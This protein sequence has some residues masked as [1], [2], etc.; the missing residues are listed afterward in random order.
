MSDNLVLSILNDGE[1]V[2]SHGVASL[3]PRRKLAG[4]AQPSSP[5]ATNVLPSLALVSTVQISVLDPSPSSAPSLLHPSEDD[6]GRRK[7]ELS[8]EWGTELARLNQPKTAHSPRLK[9]QETFGGGK[10]AVV[11]PSEKGIEAGRDRH[12]SKIQR[13][14]GDVQIFNSKDASSYDLLS[15]VGIHD[16]NELNLDND[17]DPL[18]SSSSY[19]LEEGM[20]IAEGIFGFDAP[21]DAAHSPPIYYDSLDILPTFSPNVLGGSNL[22]HYMNKGRALPSGDSWTPGSLSPPLTSPSLTFTPSEYVPSTSPSPYPPYRTLG[23]TL[24]PHQVWEQGNHAFL[25]MRSPSLPGALENKDLLLGEGTVPRRHSSGARP[26]DH[27]GVPR[28]TPRL[29]FEERSSPLPASG[30]S[31]EVPSIAKTQTIR[32]KKPRFKCDMCD[33]TFTT[34][35][36]L[37]NHVN[38]HLGIKEHSC[39][40]CGRDFTTQ[41]VLARHLKTCKSANRNF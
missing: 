4:D 24:S 20:V 26:S 27:H 37:K 19:S 34:N 33:Q 35:H 25:P 18:P 13:Q 6:F 31:L 11:E 28:N 30:S 38:V 40:S 22:A 16:S 1:A 2:T 21:F 32:T 3:S 8:Q 29:G 36:N 5:C 23:N 9:G 12:N 17:C 14:A 7:R 10:K 15:S 41:S 39:A